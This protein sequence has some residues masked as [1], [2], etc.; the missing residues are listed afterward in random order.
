[1]SKI[2]NN[3]MPQNNHSIDSNSPNSSDQ[4]NQ[5]ETSQHQQVHQAL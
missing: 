5:V 3:E 2:I 4:N 1:M